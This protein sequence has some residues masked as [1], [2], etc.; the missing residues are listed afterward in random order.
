VTTLHPFV[1]LL[2]AG[3]ANAVPPSH[4]TWER[5]SDGS[6]GHPAE[7][8]GLGGIVIPAY[9]RKPDGPGPFPA[10]VLAH[11]GRD[12]RGPTYAMGRSRRSP[13]EDFIQAGWAVY[14]IDYRPANKI[15][16]EPI[17]V[18]DTVEAVKAVRALSF[19]DSKRV[20]YLG[21]SHGAQ[22]GSRLIARVD[23]S[24]AVLC[25]PAAMDLIEDKKAIADRHEKLAPILMRLVKDME[26]KYNANAEE[27]EKDPK[28]FGYHS[29]FTEAAKVRCPILIING[30]NDDNSPVSIID[31]YVAKLRAAGKSVETYLPDNGP[32]GFYFGRPLIPESREATRRAVAFFQERFGAVKKP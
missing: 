28:K 29:A 31:R 14:S 32:H 11:G 6:L 3:L 30:R 8:Q 4:D 25:A 17:E 23:L 24:G 26:Q 7:F 27:I 1:V 12:G 21:G 13:T 9:I 2:L 20:G 15:S 19:I 10:V 5:F 22:V 16:I 18:D